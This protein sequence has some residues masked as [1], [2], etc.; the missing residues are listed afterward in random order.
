MD[1]QKYVKDEGFSPFASDETVIE[2]MKAQ[3]EDRELIKGE[4]IFSESQTQVLKCTELNCC[5]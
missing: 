2:T 4:G 3:A 5:S 1:I